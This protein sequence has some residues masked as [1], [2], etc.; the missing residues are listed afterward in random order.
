M[1]AAREEDHNPATAGDLSTMLQARTDI[2][3]GHRAEVA[4]FMEDLTASKTG[5]WM[6][7]ISLHGG[8]S[9]AAM[10]REIYRYY[11]IEE[12]VE[13]V[14]KLLDRGVVDEDGKRVSKQ[15]GH[16]PVGAMPETHSS[17]TRRTIH[18]S[19]ETRPAANKSLARGTILY[20]A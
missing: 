19:R 12:R 16:G 20:F 3:H 4:R 10:K 1:C 5:S 11:P 18:Q 9:P 17:T 14:E 6:S 13:L 15:P 8:G 7:V 2:P